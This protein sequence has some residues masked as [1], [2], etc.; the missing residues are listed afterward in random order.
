MI[1][2]SNVKELGDILEVGEIQWT[3]QDGA[4]KK[5]TNVE[6]RIQNYHSRLPVKDNGGESTFVNFGRSE[7][8][9][10]SQVVVLGE[11]NISTLDFSP[12]LVTLV[13]GDNKAN[14]TVSRATKVKLRNIKS[15]KVQISDVDFFS[16]VKKASAI[17]II[18]PFDQNGRFVL[19]EKLTEEPLIV[20][21]W[22]SYDN[23]QTHAVIVYRLFSRQMVGRMDFPL[24]DE[25][26][27]D[28]SAKDIGASYSKW[29]IS[30]I[31]SIL[32]QRESK[33]E[34]LNVNSSSKKKAS[35][36]R[37]DENYGD[38]I[39]LV[40]GVEFHDV[41]GIRSSVKLLPLS[42]IKDGNFTWDAMIKAKHETAE[43]HTNTLSCLEVQG[44][45]IYI[46]SF[47]N[48]FSIIPFNVDDQKDITLKPPSF[49]MEN[50]ITKAPT[51]ND[52]ILAV[53]PI[54]AKGTEL[55][56]SS[57]D[58]TIRYWK[59]VELEKINLWS[60]V[61]FPIEHVK[62]VGCLAYAEF[63]N[64]IAKLQNV[65][66]SHW[67]NKTV[68]EVF[69]GLRGCSSP[70]QPKSNVVKI[71][72]SGGLDGVAIVWDV[73]NPAEPKA[74]LRL[75]GHTDEITDVKV[76][77][78][79]DS[80]PVVVT[81]AKDKTIRFWDILTGNCYRKLSHKM[82]IFDMDLI[83]VCS[84]SNDSDGN[85]E[86]K[87]D[88]DLIV[89]S[90]DVSVMVWNFLSNH[91][92]SIQFSD[93]VISL[94]VFPFQIDSEELDQRWNEGLGSMKSPTC[95]ALPTVDEVNK[96]FM[97]KPE[98]SQHE[99]LLIGTNAS[100]VITSINSTQVGEVVLGRHEKKKARV[101]AIAVISIDASLDDCGPGIYFVAG[102]GDGVISIAEC[103]TN[104][105]SKSFEF[106]ELCYFSSGLVNVFSL[107]CFDPS[108]V[109]KPENNSQKSEGK[110]PAATPSSQPAMELLLYA[111]GMA[112][113]EQSNLQIWSFTKLLSAI[114]KVNNSKANN[115]SN[116]IK[117]EKLSGA[118]RVDID[119]KKAT[120]R[121]LKIHYGT[122][123]RTMLVTGDYN[124]TCTV[125]SVKHSCKLFELSGLHSTQFILDVEIFD[126]LQ[127]WI[128]AKGDKAKFSVK[129]QMDPPSNKNEKENDIDLRDHFIVCTG[130]YDGKIGLWPIRKDLIDDK[131]WESAKTINTYRSMEHDKLQS[132]TAMSIFY[133]TSGSDVYPLLFTGSIDNLIYVWDIYSQELLRVLTG[134]SNRINALKTYFLDESTPVL[135]SG[136]DDCSTVIWNDGPQ[137][138]TYPPSKHS[139]I[140]TFYSDIIAPGRWDQMKTLRK[141]HPDLFMEMPHL[142]YLA[143]IERQESFFVEFIDDLK[144]VITRIPGYSR[145][146]TGHCHWVHHVTSGKVD[147]L[148]YAMH[149]NSLVALRAI[150]LAWSHA[151]SSDIT[152][153]VNQN[154]LHTIRTFNEKNLLEL[155]TNFPVEYTDFMKS[156]RLVTAH[157]SVG[158]V[159]HKLNRVI[160]HGKRA[161][162]IGS[163]EFIHG[164]LNERFR[165]REVVLQRV[166]DFLIACKLSILRDQD[167]HAQ[168]VLPFMLPIKRFVD[169]RQF[170]CAVKTSDYLNNVDI[171]DS[172]VMITAITHYWNVFGWRLYLVN[173]LQYAFTVFLFVV[174]IYAYQQVLIMPTFSRHKVRQ[175]QL[176]VGFFV[177][178]MI[179][180]GVDEISQL[181]GKFFKL[182]KHQW[183]VARGLHL[184][185]NHL[186]FDFWN[187]IDTTVVVT[188]I[189][190]SASRLITLSDCYKGQVCDRFTEG[191]AFSSCLLAAT[192][193]MLWFKVLYFL[194]PIK[195]AGQFGKCFMSFNVE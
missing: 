66:V 7:Y 5:F 88:G 80:V 2:S 51:H 105:N 65:Q 116:E 70:D 34:N 161:V 136:S 189:L 20:V 40:L 154:T 183:S 38:S 173:F 13:D 166:F 61:Q 162:V 156:L 179:W 72:V 127:A 167:V 92:Q 117:F 104:Q 177:F 174:S 47:D 57:W 108:K 124:K 48:T 99:V 130:G 46:G 29:K 14:R 8:F 55:F 164:P 195:A 60:S 84:A 146:K 135:V 91:R 125:W 102:M 137:H 97:Y 185:V 118:Q 143:L 121:C 158:S 19:N 175:A 22:N 39:T 63:P 139:I 123:E 78:H 9:K 12:C 90:S 69:N 169:L 133:P 187:I 126:P 148:E 76:H 150:L 100:T 131:P 120:V 160:P 134:H 41:S 170:H 129:W 98:H 85:I 112:G 53:A 17:H 37:D 33:T 194:R 165:S 186:L 144:R 103:I 184:I 172:E 149:M 182:H 15:D 32:P 21:A 141:M 142:F 56:T 3:Q 171:F 26:S 36:L 191:N 106:V 11:A 45:F 140:R 101:N 147:I 75:M 62:K 71:L 18:K 157:S 10:D 44:N 49:P 151:L 190:G 178:F 79:H 132:V 115:V 23:D 64:W 24:D 159:D 59:Q 35:E 155:A 4:V 193:V 192:A 25:K 89:S 119:I 1:R 16:R 107:A 31:T 111:G 52:I 180:F 188:G 83:R 181:I 74:A 114:Y 145:S 43:I 87:V 93:P 110:T 113:S 54:D 94:A 77:R 138:H 95:K 58:T 109:L 30:C 82:P 176:A 122:Y 168:A 6:L 68:Y 28:K 42:L 152:D 96:K 163:N 27:A 153:S 50:T 73:A 67:W 81:C 128:R 86:F